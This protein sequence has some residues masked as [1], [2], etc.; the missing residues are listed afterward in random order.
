MVV[1][2]YDTSKARNPSAAAQPL[3]RALPGIPLGRKGVPQDLANLI[4]F[5]VGPAG[6]YIS[7]QTIHSNGGALMNM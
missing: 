1:G 2:T 4:R 6:G 5:L 7:G 3:L